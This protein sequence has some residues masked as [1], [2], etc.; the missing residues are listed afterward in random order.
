M[1]RLVGRNDVTNFAKSL[2]CWKSLA[3]IAAAAMPMHIASAQVTAPDPMAPL[4]DTKVVPPVVPVP[5]TPP[6]LWQMGDARS[7]LAYIG[8]I[9]SEGL[10]PRDYDPAGLDIALACDLRVVGEGATLATAYGRVGLVPGTGVVGGFHLFSSRFV[11]SRAEQ[12]P[13]V[14]DGKHTNIARAAEFKTVDAAV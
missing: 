8:T 4:P 7:L 6:P 12:M 2:A 3:L 10:D 13:R 1:S 11:A 5:P 9:A 14:V